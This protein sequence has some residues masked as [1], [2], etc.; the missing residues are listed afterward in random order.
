MLGRGQEGGQAGGGQAGGGHAEL[1]ADAPS[2]DEKADESE[3]DA[4][5]WR[6]TGRAGDEEARRI[7]RSIIEEAG[8]CRP[9]GGPGQLCWP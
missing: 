1:E 6:W 9:R 5:S 8:I 3:A 2:Q 4:P 7:R